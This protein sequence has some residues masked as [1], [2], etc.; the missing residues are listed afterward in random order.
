MSKGVMSSMGYGNNPIFMPRKP[1]SLFGNYGMPI[2]PPMPMPRPMPMQPPMQPQIPRKQPLDIFIEQQPM[3][4]QPQSL[5][6][7]PQPAEMQKP[8][9]PM[10]IGRLP[11]NLFR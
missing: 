2:Q 5:L 9:S 6:G 1:M 8:Q 11:I 4:Q 7:Q 10:S 3:A